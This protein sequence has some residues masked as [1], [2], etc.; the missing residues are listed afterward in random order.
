M[1]GK[2]D[3]GLEFLTP[4]LLPGLWKGIARANLR[5]HGKSPLWTDSLNKSYNIGDIISATCLNTIEIIS[6]K[7]ERLDW[8]ESMASFASSA[9]T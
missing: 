4:V 6:F 2:I 1:D 7:D 5:Q 8:N 3:I 9:V